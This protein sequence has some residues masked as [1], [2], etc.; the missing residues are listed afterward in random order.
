MNLVIAAAEPDDAGELLTVQRAAY[1]VEAQRYDD[2]HIAPLTETLD[3]VRA[4]ISG[5]PLSFWSPAP[6]R[7]VVTGWSARYAA[8]SST[9]PAGLGASPS[10]LTCTDTASADAC[11][12][13]SR[14]PWRPG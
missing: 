12:P 3:E 14:P 8:P 5:D 2:P 11:S 7:P 1:L 10:P 6:R 9:A 13:P 4:A